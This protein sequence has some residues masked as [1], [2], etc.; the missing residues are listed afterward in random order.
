M[1]LSLQASTI[2]Y[3]IL[4]RRDF[5]SLHDVTTQKP[6][7][8][9]VTAVRT[10][11]P[12]YWEMFF[13]GYGT[14]SLDLIDVWLAACNGIAFKNSFHPEQGSRIFPRNVGTHPRNYTGHTFSSLT[15]PDLSSQQRFLSELTN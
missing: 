8:I 13:A 6:V 2:P 7:L 3:V 10:S 5:F 1:C 9:V 14:N 11:S 12:T 4:K 15:A